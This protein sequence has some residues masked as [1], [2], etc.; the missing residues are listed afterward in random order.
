MGSYVK[1]AGKRSIAN[2]IAREMNDVD[3]YECEIRYFQRLEDTNTFILYIPSSDIL[4]KFLPHYHQD[5][6]N[7]K[8]HICIFQFILL[9]LILNRVKLP[10]LLH[11]MFKSTCN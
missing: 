7:T 3:G 8:H 2:V 4:R 11:K 6:P 1:L 5:C 9:H 10:H